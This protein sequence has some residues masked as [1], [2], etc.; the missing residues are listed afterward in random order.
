MIEFFTY[1]YLVGAIL[2]MLFLALTNAF[3]GGCNKEFVL[4]FIGM[5]FWPII[6][7]YLILKLFI[8]AIVFSIQ[9]IYSFLKF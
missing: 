1:F 8:T 7:G 9:E 6:A 5:I 2:I 4:C 3:V